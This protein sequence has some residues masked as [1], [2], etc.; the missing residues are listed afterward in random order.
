MR[1]KYDDYAKREKD[2]VMFASIAERYKS[3]QNFLAD[4]ALEPP[5]ESVVD[6][7]EKD[8]KEEQITISTIHSAKGLEWNSV[9]VIMGAGREIP[10][11]VCHGR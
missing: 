9:F 10:L 1:E 6:L 5:T 3:L 2:L 8:M 7:G 11:D 4:L